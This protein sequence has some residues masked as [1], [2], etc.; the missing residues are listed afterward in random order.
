MSTRVPHGHR[1]PARSFWEADSCY[2]QAVKTK[3][4]HGSLQRYICAGKMVS[5]RLF[6]KRWQIVILAILV[7]LGVAVVAGYRMGVRLLQ[8]KIVA[9]LGPGTGL[10][11]LKVNW[12]SIELLGLSIAAPKGWPA[13]RTL[14]AERMTIIPDLRSLVSDR[15]RISSI[16]V[17]KPYLSM[18]RTAGKLTMLP[19]LT[20][21]REKKDKKG[22][23]ARAVMI[24]TIEL[25]D[26]SMDLYDATVSRPPL[27]TR[28]ERIDAEI[29][30]VTVP[31]AGKTRF[32]LAG[33]VKGLKGDGRA[34]M[35]GWVGPAARDSSSRIELAEVDLVAFQPYLVKKHEAR[36]TKGTLDLN[37]DSEVRNNYLD[38][39]GKV[40]LRD[41]E[42]APSR[43]FFDTFMG[44]PRTA[45]I[46]FLKDHNNT[47]DVDF[48]LKGDTKHPSFS[49]N[50]SLSTRIATA[51]AGKLGVDIKSVAESVSTLGRKGMEGAGSLVE[52]VG[53]AIKGLFGDD[54]KK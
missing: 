48:V 16:I 11:Q 49:L 43:G 36:V 23:A 50:E 12:F 42:F 14:E 27:K 20:E 37:L 33:I 52:G 4:H 46:E 18:L 7:V 32:E 35:T 29:R 1:M 47:I 51:M 25:K 6:M 44:L 40:V 22:A 21:A 54:K 5:I 26:G 45:V 13:E 38:G 39:K 53:S 9:A 3:T 24:S 28:I 19:G 17:E 2:W 10:T 15:I 30:D 34:K 41:L 31:A 8:G